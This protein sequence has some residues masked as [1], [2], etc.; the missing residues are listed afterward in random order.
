MIPEVEAPKTRRTAI[1][2]RRCCVSKRTI[3]KT[4]ISDIT[5]DSSANNDTRTV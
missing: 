4:P 2:R 3:P 5:T 1:S